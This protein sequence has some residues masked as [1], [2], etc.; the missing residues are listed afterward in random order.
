MAVLTPQN[1]LQITGSVVTDHRIHK[2]TDPVVPDP[3]IHIDILTKSNAKINMN[4]VNREETTQKTKLKK[5]DAYH[6]A[7]NGDKNH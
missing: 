5:I 3:L 4:A 1:G 7:S 6:D 2:F